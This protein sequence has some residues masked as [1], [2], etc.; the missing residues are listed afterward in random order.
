MISG[1]QFHSSRLSGVGRT[2]ALCQQ[3]QVSQGG[4]AWHHWH[5]AAARNSAVAST[6]STRCRSYR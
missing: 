3:A 4:A 6:R 1:T 2:H 5:Q